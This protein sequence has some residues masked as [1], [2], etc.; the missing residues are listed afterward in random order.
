VSKQKAGD[1]RDMLP[2]LSKGSSASRDEARDAPNAGEAV[3]GADERLL[4]RC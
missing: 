3:A 4:G 1:D 2:R